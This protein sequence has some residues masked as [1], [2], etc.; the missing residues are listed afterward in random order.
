MHTIHPRLPLRR[1]ARPTAGLACLLG[2]LMAFAPA[3][4]ITPLGAT[5]NYQFGNEPATTVT[6]PHTWNACDAAEGSIGE[7][8]DAKSVDSSLYKRGAAVYTQKLTL[9]PKA[10]K[11]YFLRGGGAAIVSELSVNGKLAGRHEGS[12]TAFCYDVTSLLKKGSNTVQL[13]VDNT[14]RDHIA[15]QRGDFSTFGGLY[16]PV[17]LIETDATCIDPLFY[18]SPGVIIRTQ[19]LTADKAV[20]SVKTL[21]STTVPGGDTVDLCVTIHDAEGKPVSTATATVDVKPGNTVE[22]PIVLT[23]DNP[24]LWDGV[25]NPYVYCVEVSMAAEKGGSDKVTQPLGLRTVSIDPEKGF[26]LNGRQMQLR[27]VS[28][29]QDK[30]GKGWA[31]SPADE[32][33]DIALIREMG[34]TALRTA[35]YPQSTHIY[36]LCDREGLVVWSEVPNVNLVR[37]SAEFRANNRRQALEMIYQHG[38]HPCIC[39]WGIYNEIYHQPE[40]AQ[41]DT[42]QEEELI[43]LNAFVKAADPSRMTVAASNQPGRKKLN[44]IPDHIAFNSYPGWYGGGP[45]VMKG[46]LAGFIRNQYPKG[47]GISEYGHGASIHMHESPVG[48]PGPAAFWHPEEWQ[49]RAHEIN[50]ECIKARPEIWGSFVWNMF[51]FGSSNRCEGDLP[52]INDKGLVTYDRKVCKDAYFFYKANWNPEPM[53]YITS[54]RFVERHQPKVGWLKV[55]SNAESVELSVNGKAIGSKKPDKFMRA[56]WTNVELR[57]GKNTITVTGSSGGTITCTD[58]CVWTYKPEGAAKGARDKYI[59]PGVT[60]P[61]PGAGKK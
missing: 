56:T 30:K 45:E 8:E 4:D 21:L 19:E 33:K 44:M 49:S 1:F 37:D 23:I 6:V 3:R 61:A 39:M 31:V 51:D 29:H 32:E 54:R 20:V 47:V 10:G 34:V 60:D 48:R 46:N 40:R 11:R 43:E 12:F 53:V 7:P 26:F 5:W 50:Y 55:Y 36:D 9:T 25:A 41:Q 35:H 42:N 52:G 57:P 15:P 58:S 17:E 28:R 18:A 22:K 13:M 24:T 59:T 16:R 38:N 2:S 27:G 14:H